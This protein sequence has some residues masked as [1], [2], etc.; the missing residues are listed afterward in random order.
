MKI[1]GKICKGIK[2]SAFTFLLYVIHLV[3]FLVWLRF[4]GLEAWAI[5]FNK[6][7]YF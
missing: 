5:F 3:F 2:P 7:W 1:E 4:D 6:Y